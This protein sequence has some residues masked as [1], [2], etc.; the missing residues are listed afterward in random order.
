MD[1]LDEWLR[2]PNRKPLVLSGARQVGKTWLLKEFGRTRFD[3]V[4][5]VNF[6]K[7]EAAK[8]VFQGE[9]RLHD[10]LTDLEALSGTRI[11]PGKTL[12]ILD[13]I[14]LCPAAI[15]SL[16]YWREEAPEHVVAAAGSLIGLSLLEGSGWPVG[17]THSMTLRPLS[18]REFL[19]AVGEEPLSEAVAVG[20][21]RRFNLLSA[22]L[23]RRLKEYL[24]VG[25]MPAVVRTFAETGS[26]S[27][28]QSEQ[29]DILADYDRDFGKHAPKGLIPRIRALW[30]SLPRQLA[31]EDKRFVCSEVPSANGGKSKSRDLHDAFEWLEAAGVAHRVWNV[32]KPG[33]PLD[34]YRN[35]VFKLFGVDVGLL[36]TQSGLEP[37]TILEG[38]AIFTQ[39]KGALTEQFAQQELRATADAEPFYWTTPDS[40]TEIDFLVALSGLVIPIEA[41]AALNLRAKSLKSYRDRFS[42]VLSVRTSLASFHQEDSGL[43]DLPLYAIGNLPVIARECGDGTARPTSKT[44]NRNTDETN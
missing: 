21:A 33:L 40:R 2:G 30:K 35:H 38:D 28:A 10:A 7:S 8:A 22:R 15:R 42:P 11:M 13:E 23:T 18:F 1:Q 39:F 12:L 19:C 14:Q 32:T 37:R 36:A 25:G 44:K 29:A 26:F 9:F 27:E 6:D 24:C 3:S 20:D 31:R 41:K 16:K 43:L 34:S 5:Y 17:A 4:A